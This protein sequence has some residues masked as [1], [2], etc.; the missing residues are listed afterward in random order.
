MAI[1]FDFLKRLAPK[2]ADS[3]LEAAKA[4]AG[5]D[6]AAQALLDNMAKKEATEGAA[7]EAAEAP[8]DTA[9][10]DDLAEAAGMPAPEAETEDEEIEIDP[11]GLASLLTD[12]ADRLENLEKKETK[13]AAPAVDLAPIE[14]AFQIVNDNFTAIKEE[15][16]TTH[17]EIAA[18]KE[19]VEA[20]KKVVN[21]L[22]DGAPR[23]AQ[24]AFV[25][26]YRAAEAAETI[27]TKEEV[28]E[29]AIGKS[30]GG[31]GFDWF[32]NKVLGK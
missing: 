9:K 3:A 6:L 21:V 2:A 1:K 11:E 4:E 30:E 28:K 10:K 24:K 27:A 8:V 32:Q 17:G 13:E 22:T 7:T 5:T 18:L 25:A 20:L 12:L 23:T 14:G 19:A 15:Q 26:Q 29:F 31:D 16:A